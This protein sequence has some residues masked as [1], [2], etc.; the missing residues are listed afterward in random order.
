MREHRA[1]ITTNFLDANG[2]IEWPMREPQNQLSTRASH[3]ELH[4]KVTITIRS[5][6]TAN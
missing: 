5:P 3:H 6:S 2:N 4:E 1:V